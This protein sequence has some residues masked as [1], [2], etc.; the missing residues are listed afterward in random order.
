M[1]PEVT[2]RFKRHFQG[3][4]DAISVLALTATV[5]LP[6][7]SVVNIDRMIPGHEETVR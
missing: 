3:A 7:A 5:L 4:I 6:Q 1:S 2:E